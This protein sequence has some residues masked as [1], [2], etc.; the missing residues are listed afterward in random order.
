[1]D[2]W[3]IVETGSYRREDRPDGTTAIHLPGWHFADD[4][5]QSAITFESDD[6]SPHLVWSTNELD[7]VNIHG[8]T[9]T[10]LEQLAQGIS[11][12]Q[13]TR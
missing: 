8:H 10:E 13:E 11:A 6:D 1:M 3:T 4:Q 5:G 9:L 2:K 12:R 7:Q